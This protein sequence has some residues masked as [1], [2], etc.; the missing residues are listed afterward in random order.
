MLANSMRVEM[1]LVGELVK[2]DATNV[3]HGWQHVFVATPKIVFG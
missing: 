3:I 2:T 1:K